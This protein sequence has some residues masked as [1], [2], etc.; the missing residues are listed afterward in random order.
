MFVSLS[1]LVTCI[2]ELLIEIEDFIGFGYNEK[3]G[4]FKLLFSFDKWYYSLGSS[5]QCTSNIGLD[6]PSWIQS[7]LEEF[8]VWTYIIILLLE[9]TICVTFWL[10]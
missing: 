5:S 9:Q 3:L 8:L 7:F 1:D 4:E 2:F 6:L 10:S